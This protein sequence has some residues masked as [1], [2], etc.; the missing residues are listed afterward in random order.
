MNLTEEQKTEGRRNFLK[1][2]AGAPALAALGV[3]AVTNGPISGGPVKAGVIGVG[4]M[5]T[6][7]VARCQKEFI[8]VR[9][10]CDINPRNRQKVAEA[11]VKAGWPQPRQ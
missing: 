4:G 6:E 2:I 7:L 11:M 5:G 9:A 1:A 10:I 8:D 3:A